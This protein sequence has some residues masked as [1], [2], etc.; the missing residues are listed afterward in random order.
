MSPATP[1][2]PFDPPADR[3]RGAAQPGAAR[4][5]WMPLGVGVSH[6]HLHPAH[7]EEPAWPEPGAAGEPAAVHSRAPASLRGGAVGAGAGGPGGVPAGR[8]GGERRPPARP[9]SGALRRPGRAGRGVGRA[10]AGWG[11]GPGWAGGAGRASG[12]GTT[13]GT[14]RSGRLPDKPAAGM[15]AALLLGAL[16]TARSRVTGS[17]Q[18]LLSVALSH[19]LRATHPT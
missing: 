3:R 15:F 18:T 9:G 12:E 6:A 19:L 13:S 5:T 2:A 16:G 1:C 10:P 14:G 8:S 17:V 11:G 7:R 4:H